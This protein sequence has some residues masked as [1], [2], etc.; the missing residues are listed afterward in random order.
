MITQFPEL[1]AVLE[2]HAE[3]VRNILGDQ[4]VGYYLQGSFALGAGDEQSDADFVVVT[5]VPPAGEVENQLRQL[6]EEIPSRPGIWNIN[7]EGC[8]ADA[9]SLRALTGVGTRWLYVDRGN[10]EM[11]WSAHDNTPHTRWILRHCG[12]TVDG[13][14]IQELVDEVPRAARVQEAARALPGLLDSI[15]DW[16]NMDNAW[17]QRY[18][19]QTY[20]RVL[21]TLETGEVASKRAALE[22]GQTTLPER[23]HALLAQVA[24]DR[25]LPWK[26]VDPPRPCSVA[27]ALEF[28]AFVEAGADE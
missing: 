4:Y 14:S 22:W 16:A 20:C 10:R 11:E 19:V 23:W 1:N 8:Y 24:E 5:R 6:H 17:T 25:S 28:A 3:A 2:G 26:P 9:A 13:T 21:F 18:I 27:L 12:I 7:L 15:R